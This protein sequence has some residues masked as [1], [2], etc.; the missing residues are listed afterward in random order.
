MTNDHHG[1][2]PMSET[3]LFTPKHACLNCAYWQS[4]SAYPVGRACT[5]PESHLYLLATKSPDGCDQW[6]EKS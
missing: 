2:M 3:D 1:G 6:K 5:N 4:G